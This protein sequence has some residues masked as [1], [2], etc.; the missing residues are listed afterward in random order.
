MGLEFGERQEAQQHGDGQRRYQRG[1]KQ[2]A[3][4]R[5]RLRPGHDVFPRVWPWEGGSEAIFKAA[6][7][8]PEIDASS[9]SI[10]CRTGKWQH[11][12]ALRWLG[13]C[14]C[15]GDSSYIS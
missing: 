15:F 12:L 3:Q 8:V 5:I 2:I 1:N 9:N 13:C 14:R 4:R 11:T 6:G 7:M 10:Q